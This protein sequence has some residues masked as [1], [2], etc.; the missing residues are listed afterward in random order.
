MMIVATFC[1]TSWMASNVKEAVSMWLDLKSQPMADVLLLLP[2]LLS[3]CVSNF[4]CCKCCFANG[5]PMI[6]IKTF[7]F[8]TG[9]KYCCKCRHRSSIRP[10]LLESYKEKLDNLDKK[11]KPGEA[12]SSV[13]NATDFELN[14]WVVL[15]LQMSGNGCKEGTTLS[16][17]MNLN[18]NP[19]WNQWIEIQENMGKLILEIAEEV[20]EARTGLLADYGP[21]AVPSPRYQ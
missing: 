10:N 8:A 19:M 5:V 18:C 21:T 3:F 15:G 12:L 6:K 13:T 4:Q 1:A 16:G 17:M 2:Q 7:G 14:C 11:L 9:I 20:L